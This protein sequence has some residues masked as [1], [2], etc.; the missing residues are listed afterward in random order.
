MG[1]IE[2]QNAKKNDE[3][4]GDG[5]ELGYAG[6][7]WVRHFQPEM[8]K[9]GLVSCISPLSPRNSITIPPTPELCQT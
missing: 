9:L 6:L 2:T 5:G 3:G 4:D 8:V 1:T 7:K